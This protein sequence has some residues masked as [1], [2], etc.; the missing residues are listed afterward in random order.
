MTGCGNE[1]ISSSR[2][3]E[4]GTGGSGVGA[5]IT[6]RRRPK[7]KAKMLER[8]EAKEEEKIEEHVAMSEGEVQ[9]NEAV[10]LGETLEELHDK[11]VQAP[12]PPPLP[13]P[14]KWPT[15]ALQAQM[16]EETKS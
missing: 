10:V 16:R 3:Q 11:N 5:D 6:V 4:D 15:T 8:E 12:Y 9:T 14:M 1:E 2:L 7:T 13:S